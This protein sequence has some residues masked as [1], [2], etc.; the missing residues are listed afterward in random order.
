MDPTRRLVK[1][2]F[3]VLLCGLVLPLFTSCGDDDPVAPT[4]TVPVQPLAEIRLFTIAGTR[5]VSDTVVLS[6]ALSV[7]NFPKAGEANDNSPPVAP[8]PE[9]V[10][11]RITSTDEG[12]TRQ[13]NASNNPDYQAAI[14]ILTNGVDDFGQDFFSLVGGGA[15]GGNQRESSYLNGGILGNYDPDLSGAQITGVTVVFKRVQF[16]TPGSDPNSD[17]IWT[18]FT[19]DARVVLMGRP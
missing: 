11:V 7:A 4:S 13:I 9:L 10:S 15:V 14:A 3:V 2:V 18:D 12:T 17:G 19:I 6:F 8:T 5:A 16:D 1:F